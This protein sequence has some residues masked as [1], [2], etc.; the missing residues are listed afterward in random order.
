ML[1][2]LNTAFCIKLQIFNVK[3]CENIFFIGKRFVFSTFAITVY[4]IVN[5]EDSP[6]RM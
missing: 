3:T 2:T 4:V 6:D 5:F 1:T